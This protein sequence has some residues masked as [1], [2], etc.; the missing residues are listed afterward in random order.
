[1]KNLITLFF[2]AVGIVAATYKQASNSNLV[3]LCKPKHFSS[4]KIPGGYNVVG[5][6]AK[7]L[8]YTLGDTSPAYCYFEFYRKNPDDTTQLVVV[9]TQ[10]DYL[11]ASLLP[12]LFSG[13]KQNI[14]FA[15]KTFA[16]AQGYA[17]DTITSQTYLNALYP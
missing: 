11:P 13:N 14:Y 10:N 12:L 5:I 17:L 3:F 16:T 6:S 15:A 9:E 1:M 8:N 7:V 2:L 4:P